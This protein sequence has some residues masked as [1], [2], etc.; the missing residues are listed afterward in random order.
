MMQSPWNDVANIGTH[1]VDAANVDEGNTVT[2]LLKEMVTL[3][4]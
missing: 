3:N 1:M 2:H 4:H